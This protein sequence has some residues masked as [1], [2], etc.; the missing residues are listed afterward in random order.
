LTFTLNG[1]AVEVVDEE[2]PP[3]AFRET[4]RTETVR[5]N[6]GENVLVVHTQ[7][8]AGAHFWALGAALTTV[9][10][11]IMTDLVYA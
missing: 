11:S 7:P 5:L 10:G 1:Q 8:Q 4:Q 3:P 6:K 2:E 9:D